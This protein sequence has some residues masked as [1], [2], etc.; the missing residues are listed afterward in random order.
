LPLPFIQKLSKINY[1]DKGRDRLNLLGLP[2]F[3]TVSQL[4]NLLHIDSKRLNILFEYTER[5][6]KT[7][8]IRKRDGTLRKISQPSKE[9]KAVQAWILRN[10]LDKLNP[11]EY[12]MAYIQGK[13]LKDNITPHKSN[14]FF[15]SVDIEDFFPSISIWHVKR[16]F[17][18]LGY[19]AQAAMILRRLCVYFG[20][21]P[22][23][24]VTSPALSNLACLRLDRRLAGLTSRRNIVFTRYADDMTFSSNNRKV[25]YRTLPIILSIIQSEGFIPKKSKTRFL[26][27]RSQCRIT[28]LIKNSSEPRFGIGRKKKIQ[29]RAIMHHLVSGKSI[30]KNYSSEESIIGWLSYLKGV[31]EYSYNQMLRYW[32]NLKGKY[33]KFKSTTSKK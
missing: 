8:H 28:G 19:S 21:L 15:L 24:G 2:V 5:F 7:Y 33:P 20:G 16:I 22:Q 1:G 11:S 17:E 6:Y 26:G 31:D 9:L 12:A 10:I 29:M 32:D 14:R 4:A 30:D 3:E 13:S 25:L 23:G 27:P 18:L